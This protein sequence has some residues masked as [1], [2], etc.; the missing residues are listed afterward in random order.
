[1]RG[2]LLAIG[3]RMP[4][5]LR[6]GSPLAASLI[7]RDVEGNAYRHKVCFW[8]DRRAVATNPKS[9]NLG[10]FELAPAKIGLTIADHGSKAQVVDEGNRWAQPPTGLKPSRIP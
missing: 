9:K 5:S 6:H 2:L 1:M 8:I 10:L 7:L 3:S 4:D